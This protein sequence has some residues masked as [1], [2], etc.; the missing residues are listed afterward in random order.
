MRLRIG[1]TTMGEEAWVV[2][3]PL[4]S[5]GVGIR[6]VKHYQLKSHFYNDEYGIDP[7]SE[8]DI[9]IDS[10]APELRDSEDWRTATEQLWLELMTEDERQNQDC[11]QVEMT[12][13]SPGAGTIWVSRI[14]PTLRA[15]GFMLILYRT[16]LFIALH[17]TLLV[18]PTALPS[19]PPLRN[20]LAA[21]CQL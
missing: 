14:R 11:S 10:L 5:I 21:T 15:R 18:P 19:T 20:I 8:H 7:I 9:D 6:R 4:L 2:F 17:L 16:R 12:M 3:K 13:T 1:S